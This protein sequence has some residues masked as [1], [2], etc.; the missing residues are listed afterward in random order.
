MKQKTLISG[1]GLI[2]AAVLAVAL[3][4]VVNANL[5]SLRFDLTEN[6]LF[7]LSNSNKE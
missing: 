4:I 1:S 7:T 6:G 5:T 2:L 3:I